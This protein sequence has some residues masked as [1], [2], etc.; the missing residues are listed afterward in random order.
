MSLASRLSLLTFVSLLIAPIEARAWGVGSELDHAGCH[1][2]ITTAALRNVRAMHDTAP[3]ITPTRDEAA[4]FDDVQ[5]VPPADIEADTAAMTL[6]LGVRDNDLKGN[7]PLDTINLVRVH[8]D[9]TT[10]EEHCI[11]A[12]ADDNAIGNE[13][14]LAACRAFIIRR[15]S[16]ALEGLDASGAVDASIRRNLAVYVSVA[17]R[18]KPAL[19]LFYIR[20]GMAMHALE[21]AFTHTYRTA[22]GAHVTV[23]T[24]WIEALDGTPSDEDRDGPPHLASLDACDSPDPI[25]QRNYALAVE[26]ATA[27]L[28]AALD[29]ALTPEAKIARYEEVTATYLSFEGGCTL[30]NNYCDAP[31]PKVPESGA[32]NAAGGSSLA[33]LPVMFVVGLVVLRRRP[34]VAVALALGLAL[35]VA[36]TTAQA[37]PA[38]PAPTPTVDEAPAIPVQPQTQEDAEKAAKGEEPGRDEKTPTVQELKEVREDKRLGSPFGFTAMV[39]GSLVHGAVVGAVGGRYRLSENW[40]IGLDAEWNP[41]ITPQP[42]AWKSGATNIYATLIHR[43]PMKF[44]RANLRTSVHLGASVLLFDIYGAPQYSVGA[45]GSFAP[46][47]IDYD[48]GNSVRIVIDPVEIAVPMPHIGAIPL[49][50]EQFRLMI[51][52]QVGA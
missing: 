29:P 34:G 17:G 44:D 27:L 12:E 28:A 4:L 16:E 2:K 39:G 37:Q 46:L 42:L 30:A 50:Y 48:L 10:Q 36:A 1:E 47:G 41:W 22:D 45:F 52:I 51:G 33:W 5:F 31:E 38:E 11:R 32:C 23:V 18:V 40:I 21:D 35:T 9:P 20:M 43:Y 25:V 24:N 26:A 3:R 8:G 14:A 6:L 13:E 15:A 7:N 19:P 49:Y